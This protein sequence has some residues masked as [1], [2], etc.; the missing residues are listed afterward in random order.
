MSGDF[1][2][3]FDKL[4]AGALSP[5]VEAQCRQARAAIAELIAADREYDEAFIAAN[6]LRES[7]P[8]WESA[9]K[10]YERA[11]ERRAEALAA[12][13]GEGQG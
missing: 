4:A 10:R 3:V 11:V 7:N 5:Q 8:A 6:I 12:V 2:S 9:V 1:L 13:V